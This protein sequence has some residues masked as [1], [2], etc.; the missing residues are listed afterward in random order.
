M[1]Q[2]QLAMQE[3]QQAKL[4]AQERDQKASL[5]ARQRAVASGGMRTLMADASLGAV[6]NGGQ[7]TLG[8]GQA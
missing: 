8:S 5:L 3:Q 4:D 2:K 1:Q 6:G 7:S